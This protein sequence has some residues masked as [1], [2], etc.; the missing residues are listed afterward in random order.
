MKKSKEY[1]DLLPD[2]ETVNKAAEELVAK[3]SQN[4]IPHD[5]VGLRQIVAG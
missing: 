5:P 3:L 2:E 4:D 1:L